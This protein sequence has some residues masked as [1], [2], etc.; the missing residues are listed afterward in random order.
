MKHTPPVPTTDPL[1]RWFI[2]RITRPFREQHPE[3]FPPLRDADPSTPEQIAPK[4]KLA[5]S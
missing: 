3:L 4:C 5:E 2:L 1:Y